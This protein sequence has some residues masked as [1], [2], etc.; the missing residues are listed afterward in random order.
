MNAMLQIAVDRVKQAIALYKPSKVFALYSGG[1]DSRTAVE[2]ASR[3]KEFSGCVHFNT[4]IG[5]EET[6]EFARETCREKGW[7]LLEFKATENTKADGTPDPQIYDDNVRK[8]G[9]PGPAQHWR[10]YVHLKERSLERFMRQVKT[11]KRDSILLINGARS[12]ESVRRMS[13]TEP[14]AKKG[15]QI[16]CAAVHDWE[17]HHIKSLFEQEGI[18]RN[19]VV[20]CLGMSGECLCGAFAK[21]GELDRVATEFPYIGDRLDRLYEEVK[22]KFPWKWDEK[23]PE[24]TKFEREEKRG[25]SMMPFMPM[26]WN[27]NK[28]EQI[29]PAE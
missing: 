6:R 26:C 18:K 20:E 13:N 17:K 9:F 2:V 22:H 4:G 10:L 12:A 8:F 11:H 29:L 16:W 28:R 14:L 27:C 25:Q 7:P 5:V 1:H 23:P 24:P 3:V 19:P 21:P 15:C